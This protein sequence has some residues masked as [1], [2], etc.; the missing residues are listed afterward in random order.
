MNYC[1]FNEKC[2][3]V[4]FTVK[5]YNAVCTWIHFLNH[6]LSFVIYFPRYLYSATFHQ[7]QQKDNERKTSTKYEPKE[8]FSKVKLARSPITIFVTF[9]PLCAL[10]F[11]T[12]TH[13]THTHTHTDD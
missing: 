6:L 7:K 10:T 8:Q 2:I 3:N 5:I 4:R 1:Y 9:L 13:K 11:T 12:H